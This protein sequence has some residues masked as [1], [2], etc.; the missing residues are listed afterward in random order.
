V[1][2]HCVV[3]DRAISMDYAVSVAVSTSSGHT[4]GL[5]MLGDGDTLLRS[6]SPRG[7]AIRSALSTRD[8]D[9]G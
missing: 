3:K 9:H 8:H 2:A 1:L 4:K 5:T 7:A 6:R